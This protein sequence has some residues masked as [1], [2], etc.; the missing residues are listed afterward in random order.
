MQFRDFL[1]ILL[2]RWKTLLASLVLVLGATTWVTLNMTPVYQA[3]TRVFLSTTSGGYV[4][5]QQDLNTYV[6]LLQ[7]PV[8]LDPLRETLEL[9]PG[10]QFGVSGAV[11]EETNVLSITAT[12]ATAQLA[13]DIANTAGPELAAVGGDFSPLLASAGQR[14]E[15]TAIQPAGVPGSPKSPNLQ[16]NIALGTLAGLA[17][18][19]GLALLVQ[20]LDTRVRTEVDLRAISDRP[21]LATLRRLKDPERQPLVVESDPHS[22]AAEEY[23]KLRTNLQFVDVTTGGKHSFVVTSAMPNDGKSLTA[24]N[25]ARAMASSGMKV[26]LVDADLRHPSVARI[27]GLEGSVG[28]T[29]ILL[30]RASLNDVAQQWGET[31][32]YV[33]PAGEKPPNPSELL[34]STAMEVLFNEFL[35]VFDFVIVDSPP[36]LPVIDPV[37]LNRLVGGML[38]VASVNRTKK[39]DL[40][41]ALKNLKT[42]D[43]EPA[44]FALNMVAGGDGYGKYGYYYAYGGDS[45]G[46]KKPR[47]NA[48]NAAAVTQ[49]APVAP[50]EMPAD[51]GHMPIPAGQL[52][53]AEAQRA[54]VPRP[55]P[56]EAAETPSARGRTVA[57]RKSRLAEELDPLAFI[58]AEPVRHAAGQH[59]AFPPVRES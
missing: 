39:K 45:K 35:R 32:L 25:L 22:V 9:A 17:L 58:E 54:R 13:A 14:V 44:G 31:S 12:A 53:D 1:D 50:D 43:I 5:T 23:R 30:G 51:P 2:K 11:S 10:T 19:I 28:L 49:S 34:G 55:A 18:G 46:K 33:L 38:L 3:T 59:P 40:A 27:L 37:L 57:R 48:K 29:T 21:N 8:V 41:H 56:D 36:V 47:S 15:S 52:M 42:V 20:A 24:V 26:L 4:I 16:Q 7:S 6:E